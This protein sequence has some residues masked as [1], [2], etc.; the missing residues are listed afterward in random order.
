MSLDEHSHLQEGV[1]WASSLRAA[2]LLCRCLRD[3]N[4][5]MM[6]RLMPD[7]PRRL[8]Y[9]AAPYYNRTADEIGNYY[10]LHRCDA[11][12]SD[13]PLGWTVKAALCHQL[14]GMVPPSAARK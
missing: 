3:L 11:A 12:L 9:D 13:M 2:V 10:F 14:R 6:P 7:A 1:C 8:D 4:K 5:L